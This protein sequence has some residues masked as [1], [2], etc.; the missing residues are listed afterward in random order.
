MR[1]WRSGSRKCPFLIVWVFM[2]HLSISLPGNFVISM[3]NLEYPLHSTAG[4]LICFHTV[5][6]SCKVFWILWHHQIWSGAIPLIP[7]D[8]MIVSCED[9]HK[10]FPKVSL[11]SDIHGHEVAE[12]SAWLVLLALP[13]Y[14]LSA[15]L[16]FS[17]IVNLGFHHLRKQSH[18]VIQ[19]VTIEVLHVCFWC[20]L[21]L[22][23]LI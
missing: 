19:R 1:S 14:T 12:Y 20:S 22:E 2:F 4:Y 23:K 7:F 21:L 3:H 16:A 15:L 11:L 13:S 10:F 5:P 9:S 17:R 18:K 8:M 6:K